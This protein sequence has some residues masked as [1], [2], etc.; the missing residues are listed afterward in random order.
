MTCLRDAPRN[1][2]HSCVIALIWNAFQPRRPR[3]GAEL[4]EQALK[5]SQKAALVS[6]AFFAVLKVEGDAA[7][8]LRDRMP[9][10]F[11]PPGELPSPSWVAGGQSD[12]APEAAV[13][14]ALSGSVD[15]N[16]ASDQ[17]FA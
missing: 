1:W 10:N 15:L 14:S 16:S 8:A 12:V 4:E 13:C 17:L 6:N 9:S 2:K 7:L 11:R 5:A 3:K